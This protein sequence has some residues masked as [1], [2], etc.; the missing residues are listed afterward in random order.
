MERNKEKFMEVEAYQLKGDVEESTQTT[1]M[2]PQ[3]SEN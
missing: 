1:F 3:D 2:L